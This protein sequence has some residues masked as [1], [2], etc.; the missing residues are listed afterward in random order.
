MPLAELPAKNLRGYGGSALSQADW[1]ARLDTPD[2]HVLE[3]V[4]TEGADLHMPEL[5]ALRLLGEALQV[6][7]RGEVARGEFEPAIGTAKTMFALARHLGDN[8]TSAA[9]LLGVSIADMALDTLT[10]MLQQPGCPNLYW[11]LTDLPSPLVDLRKGAQGDRAMVAAEWRQLKEDAPMTGAELD[12][13][14][15]HFSG[16]TGFAR[17]QAGRPPRNLRAVLTARGRDADQMRDAR[18]RLIAAGYP[19]H[20]VLRFPALQVLLLDEKR[21]CEARLDEE[22]KVLALA[23]WQVDQVSKEAARGGDGL[24]ADL[25]PRVGQARREQAR[26][27][28]RV[29]LLRHVEALRLHAAAHDRKLPEKLGDVGVPLPSDPFTG[30]PFDYQ[31]DGPTAR[32]RAGVL[33]YEITIRK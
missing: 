19:W 22:T 2:W 6:R 32:L 29:A 20:L 3:R 30:K 21:E 11:A 9:N 10:E 26:F 27:E 16:R 15:G 23:P 33:R 1:G 4:Q 31:L 7:F 24:F 14:V 28:Q 12:E 13:L 18:S 25:L 8:P 17:E 5:P